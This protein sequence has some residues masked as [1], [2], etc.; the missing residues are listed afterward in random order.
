MTMMSILISMTWSFAN[1][2]QDICDALKVQNQAPIENS[3]SADCLERSIVNPP[4][5]TLLCQTRDRRKGFN[6]ILKES[7][8]QRSPYPSLTR[9]CIFSGV[10]VCTVHNY[11]YAAAGFNA[12]RLGWAIGLES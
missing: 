2:Q 11:A 9:K 10:R 5:T 1:F 6:Y 12:A 4:S 3:R 8:S 7:P